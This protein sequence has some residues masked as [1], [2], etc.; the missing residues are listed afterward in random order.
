MTLSKL[1]KLCGHHNTAL[2]HFRPLSEVS[3]TSLEF[4]PIPPPWPQP[5]AAIHLPAVSR[6]VVILD[7]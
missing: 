1:N 4:I 5:Q 6:D 3:C 7:I 2:D